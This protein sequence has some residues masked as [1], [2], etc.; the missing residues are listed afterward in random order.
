MRNFNNIV[1]NEK[2]R[3]NKETGL[4]HTKKPFS[5]GTLVVHLN[6]VMLEPGKWCAY[7]VKGDQSIKLDKRLDKVKST[8]R[9][10]ASYIVKNRYN[11]L[12]RKQPIMNSNTTTVKRIQKNIR[13]RWNRYEVS[14]NVNGVTKRG[15]F[16]RLKEARE[17]LKSIH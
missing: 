13:K 16:T 1:T 2:L 15:S 5:T 10:L 7:I 17:F 12:N 9:I 8:D 14:K 3:L 11:K 4:Y 6:G